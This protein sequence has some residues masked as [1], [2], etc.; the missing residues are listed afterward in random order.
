[1]IDAA[2]EPNDRKHAMTSDRSATDLTDRG[3]DEHGPDP[4]NPATRRCWRCLQNFACHADDVVAG[5]PQWWLCDSCQLT[6]I[7]PRSNRTPG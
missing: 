4:S 3:A 2:P 6:L 5:P 7:G 1:L